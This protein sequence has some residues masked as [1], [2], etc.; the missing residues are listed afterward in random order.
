MVGQSSNGIEVEMSFQKLCQLDEL[1]LNA[2]REFLV[3]GQ[4]IA[5]FRTSEAVYAIDGM[6]AHQGGPIAQGKLDGNCVTCPWHGWQYNICTGVNL[7]TQK[8]MLQDFAIEV[9]S[10]EVWID[11]TNQKP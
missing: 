4:I 11:L 5:V 6:C 10:N 8:K 7:L 2:G 1:V 9:R 3:D